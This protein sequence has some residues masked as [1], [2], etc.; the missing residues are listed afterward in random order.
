MDVKNIIIPAGLM[1]YSYSSNAALEKMLQQQQQTIS[2]I[3]STLGELDETV[4]AQGETI[5]QLTGG[6]DKGGDVKGSPI[7]NSGKIQV[8]LTLKTAN[9]STADYYDAA[10][11][12]TIINTYSA[13]DGINFHLLGF[14]MCEPGITITTETGGDI[15]FPMLFARDSSLKTNEKDIVY[16][17][18]NSVLYCGER[19]INL[20]PITCRKNFLH[21]P[22]KSYRDKLRKF[23][24][25][26][27]NN[28]HNTKKKYYSSISDFTVKKL[29][30]GKCNINLKLQKQDVPSSM[31]WFTFR[32]VPVHFEHYGDISS[33]SNIGGYIGGDNPQNFGYNTI[34]DPNDEK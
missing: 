3:S 26:L 9:F 1:Y 33:Y 32:D 14:S 5:K 4:K 10:L 29:N 23:V 22:E 6:N 24:V 2:A 31:D 13:E 25:D 17:G 28:E 18:L 21:V 20:S 12:M 7:I 34:I 30:A 19:K 11:C 16:C 27:Y 8:Y 15:T